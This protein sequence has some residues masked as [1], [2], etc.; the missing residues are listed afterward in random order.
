MLAVAPN[1]GRHTRQDHPN[2][3]LTPAALA[4]TAAECLEAGANLLHVHVRDHQ[5]RHTLDAAAYHEAFT[6]IRHEVGDGLVL[7]TTTEAIGQY[8]APQQMEAVRALRPEAVS[9]AVAE[10]FSGAA[11]EREVATFLAELALDQVLVQYILYSADDQRHLQALVQRGTVP[12]P[13][14]TL[15]VLGRY[16]QPRLSTP[17]DLLAFPPFSGPVTAPWAVCA[18]GPGELRC[19][20]AAVAFGGHVRIGFE[21][22]FQTPDGQT[23]ASNAAQV[24]QLVAGLSALGAVP[25]SAAQL[26]A[27]WQQPQG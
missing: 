25:M 9:L 16:G 14:W 15:Y 22:N 3:P 11:S 23:A 26:R 6:A 1:G 27:I 13:F 8:T 24:R 21:N 5:G 20:L 4:A 18:F 2:L 17:Q 12:L 19:A 7:Q 10:L